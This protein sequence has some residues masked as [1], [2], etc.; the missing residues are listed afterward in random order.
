MQNLVSGNL[1]KIL[2]FPYFR[3][4]GG[5][6]EGY[7]NFLILFF[8]IRGEGG[9]QEVYQNVLIF[10]VPMAGEGGGQCK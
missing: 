5:G 2:R 6:Q 9:G 7:K 8:R 3:E 1:Q 4:E 10:Y